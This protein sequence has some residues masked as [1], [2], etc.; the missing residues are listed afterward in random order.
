M[1]IVAIL[2]WYDERASWLAGV[3]ASLAK[4]DVSH[5]VAVDG[6]YALYPGGKPYS[7]SEQQD[8]IRETAH[9]LQMGCTIVTP[10]EVWFG[11]EVEKRNHAFAIAETLTSDEDWYFLVD[12]DHFVTSALGLRGQLEQTDCD[13]GEVR[14]WERYGAIESGGPLRCVFRALRGLRFDSNH[15]TYRIPDGRDLHAPT[16]PTVDLNMVEVEHRTMH[17]DRYRKETQQ[18]YYSRR[19]ELGVEQP[20]EVTA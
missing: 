11:N 5:I 14:F 6:A 8:S 16:E 9:A 15:Y 1:K 2:C 19:D 20:A 10:Q 17:R 13:V 3:V 18:R 7:G 12:A 4:A